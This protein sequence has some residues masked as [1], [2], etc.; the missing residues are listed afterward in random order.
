[1][2]GLYKIYKIINDI[3]NMVYI[4]S[5]KQTLLNRWY[6]HMTDIKHEKIST[7]KISTH[8][9]LIGKEHFKI[10]LIEEI[11]CDR[12]TSKKREQVYL[13]GIPLEC[14]LNSCR[15]HIPNKN[16]RTNFMAKRKNRRDYYYRKKQNP[17][18]VEQEKTRNRERMRIK[19]K[20][21]YNQ[22][23]VSETKRQ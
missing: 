17:E 13:F 18:W 14:R 8:I 12:I 7:K 5:T 19:R 20:I 9:N 4:G 22:D 15:A 23:T 2:T 1:M 3:D 16:Y 6:G 11:I 21:K 10:E